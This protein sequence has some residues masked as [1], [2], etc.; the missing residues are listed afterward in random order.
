MSEELKNTEEPPVPP[1][2]GDD[3]WTR[4]R[5]EIGSEARELVGE[6][7]EAVDETTHAIRDRVKADAGRVGRVTDLF[8]QGSVGLLLGL[9]LGATAVLTAL[10]FSESFPYPYMYFIMGMLLWGVYT[11]RFRA[12][13]LRRYGAAMRSAVVNLLLTAFWVYVLLDQIDSRPVL[14]GSLRVRPDV[15]MMWLPAAMYAAA[16]VGMVVHGVIDHVRRRRSES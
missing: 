7:G 1:P 4:R 6:L 5:A 11:M 10:V 15:V 3:A 16:Q 8:R 9:H 13:R 12:L 2:D 14:V